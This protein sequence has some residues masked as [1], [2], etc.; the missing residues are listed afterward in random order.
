MILPFFIFIILCILFL[1]LLIIGKQSHILSYKEAIA[2][3]LVWVCI[4]IGFYFFILFFGETIH[5]IKDYS[6][7]CKQINL[8]EPYLKITKFDYPSLVLFYKKLI[9]TEFL[10]GYLM[11]Y[12]LSIDN[13]FVIMMILSTFKVE[14]KYTKTVLFWGILGAILLR[15]L[16]IFVGSSL[17]KRYEW[18]LYIFG[19]FLIYSSVKIFFNQKTENFLLEKNKFIQMLSKIFPLHN[20]FVNGKFY[21]YIDGKFFLTPLFFV[22]IIIEFTDLVFAFDSI[23]AIFSITRDPYIVFFSNILAIIG[24]RS[25]FFTLS[26]IVNM[27]RFLKYGISVLL[28]FIGIKLLF[29]KFLIEIG[30]KTE[31][32]LYFILMVLTFSILASISIPTNDKINLIN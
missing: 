16:F 11:E 29:H 13:I 12:T 18:V 17:I 20:K 15:L 19:L 23:P 5:G 21:I 4:A 30:F 26:K 10:T 24:L 22:V 31:Y 14:E 32:S 7:L 28:A 9:A 25:L 1:D 27:F 2:W 6:T 8:Y 3:T